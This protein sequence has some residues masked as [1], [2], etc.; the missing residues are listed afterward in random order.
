MKILQVTHANELKAQSL[1]PRMNQGYTKQCTHDKDN[2]KQGLIMVKHERKL[3]VVEPKHAR[4]A[5][6]TQDACYANMQDYSTS[7]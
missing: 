5:V 6:Q 1:H 7:M 4:I 2:T 3:L